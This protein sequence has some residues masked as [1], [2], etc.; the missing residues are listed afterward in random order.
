MVELT[1]GGSGGGIAQLTLHG[2]RIL[3]LYQE[4]E[5]ES[6]KAAAPYGRKLARLLS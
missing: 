5:E 6:C 4:M 2:K 1:R 3:T